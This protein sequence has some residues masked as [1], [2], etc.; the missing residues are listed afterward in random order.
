MRTVE[1]FVWILHKQ[2]FFQIDLT[3]W[4]V[5]GRF[6]KKL[7]G[8]SIFSFNSLRYMYQPETQSM[9]YHSNTF[10]VTDSLVNV[11]WTIEIALKPSYAQNHAW[12]TYSSL[13]KLKMDR[14]GFGPSWIWAALIRIYR[15]HG[16]QSE[17]RQNWQLR[18]NYWRR[19][20]PGQILSRIFRMESRSK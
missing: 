3:S 19:W 2:Y 14:H 6:F 1:S 15:N 16:W 10:L 12:I 5:F 9:S 4:S 7:F 8:Q 11:L 18:Q 17:T 20:R 13:C